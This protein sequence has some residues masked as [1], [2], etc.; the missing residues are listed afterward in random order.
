MRRKKDDVLKPNQ[1]AYPYYYQHP[2]SNH[3]PREPNQM[4]Y[5]LPI[6]APKTFVTFYVGLDTT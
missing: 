3:A 1:M 5:L 6:H 2:L 4:A